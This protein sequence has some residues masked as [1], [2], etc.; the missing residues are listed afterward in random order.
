MSYKKIADFW[1]EIFSKEEIFVHTSADLGHERLNDAV[2]WLCKDISSI[3]DFGCGNGTMLFKCALRGTTEHIG[4]DLS[5]EGIDLAKRRSI[6]NRNASFDFYKGSLD[7]L[8]EMPDK[9]VQGVILSN[10]L[11]NLTPKDAIN[12]LTHVDRVLQNNGK[13]LI[14]LNPYLTRDKIEEWNIKVIEDN[15]LDDGLY[16]WNLTSEE[17]KSI[18]SNKF[19]IVSYEEI[20]YPRY[21]QYNR[22]FLLTK[23]K[24]EI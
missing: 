19:E 4:I 3:L 15:L 1:D 8:R 18:L 16:L 20:Y 17:W 24:Q 22:L 23:L 10:I 14:K 12:T 6:N 9:N 2:D 11:D 21:E 13:I 5:T 7:V